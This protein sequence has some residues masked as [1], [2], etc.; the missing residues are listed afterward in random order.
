MCDR[1]YR[2]YIDDQLD[3]V[4][5]H[6]ERI[7]NQFGHHKCHR[8]PPGHPGARGAIGETGVTGLPG[9]IGSRGATGPIGVTG[10]TGETGETGD[11][12]DIGPKGEAGLMGAGGTTGPTGETG[13]TGPVIDGPIGATGNDGPI[14]AT[15]PTGADGEMGET[16]VTGPPG[17]VIY[18]S[19][20]AESNSYTRDGADFFPREYQITVPVTGDNQL[21]LDPDGALTFLVGGGVKIPYLVTVQAQ[22]SNVTLPQGNYFLGMRFSNYYWGG[23]LVKP[24]HNIILNNEQ[25]TPLYL[26]VSDIMFAYASDQTQVQLQL[27]P[28][29]NDN[30][31]ISTKLAVHQL[32]SVQ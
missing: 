13:M 7:V 4:L 22:I 18:Y 15:G 5:L 12:G 9:Q 32:T 17:D 20:Q 28:E 31:I 27:P 30:V 26:S 3:H 19:F 14:G 23:P 25:T 21:M 11:R 29:I 24:S 8:G 10:E 2:K 1:N 6:T 16:G